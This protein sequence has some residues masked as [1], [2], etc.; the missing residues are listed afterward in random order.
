MKDFLFLHDFDYIHIPISMYS[1][2]FIFIY[3][4]IWKGGVRFREF[5]TLFPYVY[6]YNSLLFYAYYAFLLFYSL[7]SVC[8]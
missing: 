7:I 8:I 1:V 2:F 6:M 5:R 4:K 3:V